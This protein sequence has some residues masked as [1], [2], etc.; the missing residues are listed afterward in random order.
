MG[1]IYLKPG[2][3]V[4]RSEADDLQTD[5]LDDTKEARESQKTVLRMHTIIGFLKCGS[6]VYHTVLA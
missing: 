5:I 1:K 6:T 2:E 3:L 4:L